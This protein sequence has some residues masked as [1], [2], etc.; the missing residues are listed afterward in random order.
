MI[1][2]IY[3]LF[4]FLPIICNAQYDT[5]WTHTYG[6][7]GNDNC[8][9]IINTHDGGAM[10]IGST[11]SFGLGSSQMY[12]LKLD[13]IGKIQWSTTFGGS[14]VEWGNSV[15]QTHDKGYVGAGYTTSFGKGGYD[16]YIV[17]IDSTGKHKWTYVNG[18][19]D[20]DFVNDIFEYAPGE[21]IATGKTYSFNAKDVDGWIFKLSDGKTT[22]DWQKFFS[23][24]KEDVFHAAT[25]AGDGTIMSV[26]STSSEGKGKEDLLIC[27]YKANGDLISYKT[28]GDSLNDDIK[29][30]ISNAD[31]FVITGKRTDTTNKKERPYIMKI[32]TNGKEI[33]LERWATLLVGTGSK[34]IHY[35]GG[36]Y[37]VV[38]TTKMASHGNDFFVGVTYGGTGIFWKGT[39]HGKPNSDVA[40]G[41]IRLP[42]GNMFLAGT[43]TSYNASFSDI[44]VYQTDQNGFIQNNQVYTFFEDKV[45]TVSTPDHTSNE[46]ARVKVWYQNSDQL[47]NISLTENKSY[48]Y[49]LFNSVGQL[50][51]QGQ[52]HSEN[53]QI[54]LNSFP[55]GIYILKIHSKEKNIFT[56]KFA[57]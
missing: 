2:F 8:Q 4:L 47:L 36:S 11:S 51:T 19:K 31:D 41:I 49:S 29:D 48:S 46:T 30:I 57:R 5:T 6:G 35:G 52:T 56:H 18:G 27:R 17:K 7:F 16:A 3:I 38:G 14:G 43:T 42:N 24:N 55:K 22:P 37:G 50:V 20:W 10:I 32:D 33:W 9:D 34:V 26:G 13:S 23:G 44:L 39:T 45:M 40:N 25:K 15:I 1:R 12:F 21:Y 54:D 53:F 28:H